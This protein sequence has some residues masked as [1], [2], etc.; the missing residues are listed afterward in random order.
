[1]KELSKNQNEVFEFIYNTFFS[2]GGELESMIDDEP[3]MEDFIEDVKYVIKDFILGENIN[4]IDELKFVSSS[5]EWWE[6]Y[7]SFDCRDDKFRESI[8]MIEVDEELSFGEL[9][10]SFM[11]IFSCEYTDGKLYQSSQTGAPINGDYFDLVIS[12]K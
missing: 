1:M 2:C 5:P 12:K 9:E 10:T 3:E 7:A 8:K 6:E 11:D 4:S